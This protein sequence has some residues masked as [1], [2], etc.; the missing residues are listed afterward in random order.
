MTR[1][2]RPRLGVN[3]LWLRPGVVGGSEEYLVRQLLGLAELGEPVD[4]TLFGLPSLR[5]AHPDL[6]AAFDIVEAPVSGASRPLRVAAEATWL[7]AQ[8][9]RRRLG[10]VHHGGGTVP[11]RTGGAPVVLTVHDLQV[12]RFPEFFSPFKRAYLRAS[13]PRAVRRAAVVCV[14]SAFVAGTV[15][16]AYGVPA[17]RLVVVPHGLPDAAPGWGA[18]P[19]PAAAPWP[20]SAATPEA[21]LRRRYA[22]PERFVV[23][24]A[25]THP[26]K[27]HVTLLRALARVSD[28]GAVLLGGAGRAEGD[29][30]AEISRLG[31]G[32]RVVRPG[33]IPDADRDGCYA[34]A[35]ALAF[36]SRYEGF[37]APVL[38]AMA[39]G[40]PVL[41]AD[42]TALPEVVGGA[43]VLLPAGDLDAW[44]AALRRMVDD[45]AERAALAAAG[46]R[47]AA[48]YTAA[49]SARALV[50]A[51]RSVLPW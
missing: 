9:R 39:L 33:R 32:A 26:H 48:G 17:E 21:E 11:A 35:L 30:V 8:V 38:E 15:A 18:A 3:L 46:R 22:L 47:R 34:A 5:T 37:G 41:A 27:D 50:S 25:I 24:P 13:L 42:A 43:G 16:E 44:A 7:A 49:H 45:P 4:V 36:P 40:C 20:G 1:P 31:L 19:A 23:Y 6:A 10:L 14:P 12:L 51:Y 28:L 29:V 2:A